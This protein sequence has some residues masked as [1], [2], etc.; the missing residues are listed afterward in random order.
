MEEE[1][2]PSG[3]KGKKIN[4]YTESFRRAVVREIEEKKMTINQAEKVHS[5]PHSTLS[6]WLKRY[7][8]GVDTPQAV[9]RINHYDKDISA[10]QKENEALRKALE[11]SK[12]RILGLETMIDVAENDLSINIRKKSGTKRLKK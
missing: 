1:K 8:I 2:K 3:R 9:L 4:Y 12:N 11:N 7:R 5:I 6:G 10:L